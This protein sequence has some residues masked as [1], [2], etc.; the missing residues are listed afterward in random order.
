MGGSH[1][2][3]MPEASANMYDMW[4]Y[5]NHG[6]DS[7]ILCMQHY[8]GNDDEDVPHDFMRKDFT[9]GKQCIVCRA[10]EMSNQYSL[11]QPEYQRR[12]IVKMAA[13]IKAFF[14]ILGENGHTVENPQNNFV[15]FLKDITY[16]MVGNKRC[17]HGKVL[18]KALSH[19]GTVRFPET[20]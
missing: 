19:F 11:W 18:L 9:W 8:N 5:V 10:N 6:C 4:F 14:A 13:R 15:Q 2:E 1:R 12:T 16:S 3:N 7:T 20:V 17:E